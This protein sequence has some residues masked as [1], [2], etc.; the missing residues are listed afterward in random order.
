MTCL[1]TVSVIQSK[2]DVKSVLDVMDTWCL[3]LLETEVRAM[4]EKTNLN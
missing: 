3:L 1:E 2:T 4:D